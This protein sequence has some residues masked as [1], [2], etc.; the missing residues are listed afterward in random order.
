MLLVYSILNIQQVYLEDKN[1]KINSKKIYLFLNIFNIYDFEKLRASKISLIDTKISLNIKNIITFYKKLTSKQNKISFKNLTIEIYNNKEPIIN[2][3]K[4]NYSNYGYKKNNL[5]G[6]I[7]NKRFELDIKGKF[8]KIIF[9]IL[10]TGIFGEIK[11]LNI[12]NPLE[13]TGKFK[14]KVLSSKIK[15]DFKTDKKNLNIRNFFFRNKYLSFKSDGI[16]TLSPFL[17]IDLKSKI[18]DFDKD[19]FNKI[20]F[21]KLLENKDLLKRLNTNQEINFSSKKF[22][23]DIINDL[24]VKLSLAYGRIVIKKNIFLNEGEILCNSE[25]NLIE[26]NPILIFNCFLN[27]MDKKKF[28]KNFSIDYEKKNEYLNL[29]IKGNLNLNKKK[30]N[31][32]EI[33]TNNT[34]EASEEDLKF[35]KDAFEGLLLEKNL[36][37]IFKINKVNNF[38]KEII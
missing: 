13:K 26:E 4:V 3:T 20:D 32:L 27:T 33:Q 24:N 12:A 38:I 2:L 30:I 9:K 1:F 10:K 23:R 37:D 6:D 8:E 7:F 25:M 34:Y 14:A 15:L 11:Y 5:S 19:I 35:Y 28:L 21:K 31:F 22:S 16:I 17:N 29:K 18:N 36:L